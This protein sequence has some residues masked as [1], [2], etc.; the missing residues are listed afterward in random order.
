M[1][2]NSELKKKKIEKKYNKKKISKIKG[3]QQKQLIEGSS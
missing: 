3:T 2:S 1:K